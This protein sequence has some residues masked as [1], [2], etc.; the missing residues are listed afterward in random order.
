MPFLS[1][2]A[3][4]TLV[5]EFAN[6]TKIDLSNMDLTKEEVNEKENRTDY[7][8]RFEGNEQHDASIGDA[9]QFFKFDVHGNY[10]GSVGSG[11]ELPEAWER[12]W[13]EQTLF[14][15]FHLFSFLSIMILIIV[16]GIR[17]LLQLIK[18]NEPNW[19]L[20]LYF[21]GLFYIINIIDFM[22]SATRL[23]YYK[24]EEPFIFYMF[25]NIAEGCFLEPITTCIFIGALTL[26][27]NMA[28]PKFFS[29]FNKENRRIYMKDALI[30]FLCSIGLFSIYASINTLLTAYHSSFIGS[31]T[32]NVPQMNKYL[33]FINSI[34]NVMES[35]LPPML[36]LVGIIYIYN[37]LSENK[38]IP[39]PLLL[40]ML[41]LPFILPGEGPIL[42]YFIINIFWFV[43][44]LFLIKY[45]WR[46]NPLSFLLGAF[47]F[48]VL[49]D[50]LNL[51]SKVQDPSYRNQILLAIF[52]I[53]TFILYFMKD[54]FTN[55]TI[56]N[57]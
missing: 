36:L 28:W 47:S 15:N 6:N 45:Y 37:R 48:Q 50:I 51:L 44:I 31:S 23:F 22:N 26:S 42:I 19:K 29:S 25:K 40:L 49:P 18:N 16:L 12:K 13:R 21:A 20:A 52:F 34:M 55:K 1:K 35:T 10:I 38:K 11:H 56:T 53:A 4:L 17:Y 5:K 24:T 57:E 9:K 54:L 7:H 27:I 8:F 39:K 33:P 32:F 3:A 30:S 46:F 14:D 41:S 2:N 43:I